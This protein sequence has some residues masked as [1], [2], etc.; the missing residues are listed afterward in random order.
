MDYNSNY[1]Y[2]GNQ[3]G[4]SQPGIP[5]SPGETY[6]KIRGEKKAVRLIGTVAGICVIAYVL[7]Q[8]AVSLPVVFFLSLAKL[9]K[10]SDEFFYLFTIVA[11]VAGLLI[12]FI[13]GG[14]YLKKK[15]GAEIYYLG[16]PKDKTLAVL[17]VP[18]GF[19]V[20]IIGNI[21]TNLFVAWMS[22]HG[23]N[24]TSPDFKTPDTASGIVLYIIAIAVIPALVEELAV[25]GCIMQPLRRYGDLFAVVASAVLFAVLHGNLVQAPFALVAGLAF[26]YICCVTGT[27]WPTIIIH[28]ANNLYSVI[29][30]MLIAS[31]EEEKLNI[32]L[33]FIEYFFIGTGVIC[34]VAFVRRASSLKAG[35][36]KSTTVIGGG[37]KASAFIINIP[38]IIAL[39]MMLFIT[40][41]YIGIMS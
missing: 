36:K 17:A 19:L 25:R 37:A 11:S 18:A 21:L 14:N 34:A 4:G 39:L 20:C 1:S 22:S 24:L 9:F 31:V 15:T 10:N 41:Q 3:P 8:N 5:G 2:N 7:I 30:T 38:M 28:F 16:P 29:E 23:M 13:A 12:P 33:T 32:I 26:G 40:S 6:L 27:L 35:L